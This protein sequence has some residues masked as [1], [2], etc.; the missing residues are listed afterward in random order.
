[1]RDNFYTS[2]VIGLLIWLLIVCVGLLLYVIIIEQEDKE[3][4]LI[5][6]EYISSHMVTQEQWEEGLII[7]VE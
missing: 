6:M 5:R 1:M 3:E 7:N 2:H 4:I